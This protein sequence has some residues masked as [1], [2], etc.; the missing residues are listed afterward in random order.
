[1]W[2]D[3][4]GGGGKRQTYDTFPN[5]KNH[6]IIIALTFGRISGADVF[7]IELVRQLQDQGLSAEIV[8]TAWHERAPDPLKLPTD[9]SIQNLPVPVHATWQT[10]W[11]TMTRYLEER[12]PCICL[13]NYDW[14][15]SCISPTLSGHVKIVGIAHSDDPQ[16]YEHVGRLG[17]YWDGI[18]G[19]NRKISEHIAELEPS[20]IERLYTVPYGVH[21]P[22]E[23]SQEK[24][25]A[26]RAFST[27]A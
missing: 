9:I 19:V 5:L 2:G 21:V 24:R 27:R 1:M 3:Y 12:A 4:E 22:S 16:H 25:A 14:R 10:R 6:R 15:H 20:L 7:S 23:L 8:C 17:H 26:A 11:E 18:V 13:P